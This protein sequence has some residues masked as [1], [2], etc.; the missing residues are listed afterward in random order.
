[1]D[2]EQPLLPLDER[3][4]QAEQYSLDLEPEK[5]EQPSTEVQAGSCPYHVAFTYECPYC[6]PR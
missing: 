6:N 3:F 4:R 5:T 1:M 2:H